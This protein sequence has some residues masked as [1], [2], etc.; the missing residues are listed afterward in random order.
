[1]KR[2][3]QC[4]ADLMSHEERYCDACQDERERR[5]LLRDPFERSETVRDSS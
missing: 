1:M 4:K 3:R 2:C 5:W